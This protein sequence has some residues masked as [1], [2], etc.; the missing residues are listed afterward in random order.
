MPQV[1]CL[2]LTLQRAWNS[3]PSASSIYYSSALLLR[4]TQ[5][6]GDQEIIPINM[7]SYL[8]AFL[9]FLLLVDQTLSASFHVPTSSTAKIFGGRGGK[10]LKDILQNVVEDL[11]KQKL[12]PPQPNAPPKQIKGLSHI[13][14]YLSNYGYLQSSGPFND[15][16][17]Q[18]TK[19]A[20]TTYQ[21]YFNLQATGDLNN[22]T[23]QK[24]LQQRCAIP[25]MNFTYGFTDNVS[26]PKAGN[27][28]FPK[29]NL[30][31]GFLPAS[32]IPANM[33]K[34]FRGA[35]TQWAQATGVLNLTE[36]TYDN[37]DIKVGFYNFT[38]LEIDEE[39]DGGSVI[40]LQP[41]SN[42]KTAGVI[43][44]DGTKF[45]ALPTTAPAPSSVEFATLNF[46]YSLYIIPQLF[47]V[48]SSSRDQEIAIS[49]K[50]YLSA[51]L[52]FLLLVDLS[53]SPTA[54]LN[55]VPVGKGIEEFGSK[56]ASKS[57]STWVNYLKKTFKKLP[58]PQP[59]APPEQ[60]QG[61]SR[62]KDY[63]SNYGYLQSSGPFNYSLDQETIPAIKTYQQHFN[64]Q[65]TGDLNNQ[66]L[67]QISLLRCGVP[68]MNFYY[69]F[70]DNV[71]YPKAGNRWFH[72][73]NLTCGFLPA[74]QIPPNATKVFRDSFTRWAQATGVLNLTE[75][76]YDN[77]DIKVGFY[78]FT[79]LE[80][81]EEV[82]GG[83]IIL[84]QP[85]SNVTIAGVILLD[86]TKFR[87]PP[88]ENDSLSWQDGVLDLETR[89]MH[90]IVL[91]FSGV[92][93][94]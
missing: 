85:A 33:T 77:S 1:F 2:G 83:S 13:K 82:D 35:F 59:N 52:L 86:G 93:V 74:S 46:L 14:D 28:W 20:I 23:L 53:L 17:D 61:L 37:A 75:T 66:T 64:P 3:Q 41:D 81:D 67:Q 31:Y 89:A 9:L 11:I 60:I 80:I 78:N 65:V 70:T 50:S 24:I 49:M 84:L 92:L 48:D 87:A 40:L 27:Q 57:I 90:Q 94:G 45:W 76:T 47:Y 34:V 62:I 79:Y 91:G 73:T 72:K 88:S 38:Y 8:F 25:D 6:L 32:E 55:P 19:A 22:Q 54:G 56:K 15:S 36:T 30:T 5:A 4:R 29:G 43:L 21:Q 68:D 7:K 26:L 71:S 10:V 44:L 51:P 63:F 16:L 12:S 42:V 58:S 18:E 69:N 39:V